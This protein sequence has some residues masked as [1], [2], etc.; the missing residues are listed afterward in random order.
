MRPFDL[1]LAGAE[2]P[3]W[4]KLLVEAQ[5]PMAASYKG[6]ERRMAKT[7]PYL[8]AEKFEGDYPLLLDSG[9]H[10]FNGSKTPPPRDE[11]LAYAQ[12]Y[13]AFVEANIDRVTL[14]TEFDS[15]HLGLDWVMERRTAFYDHLDP[16]KFVAVWHPDWG[17]DVLRD[18]SG[19]YEAVGVTGTESAT[20]SNLTPL[21]HSIGRAG[22]HLHGMAITKPD[23]LRVLPF[24]SA[25]ST[26]WL[27][28]MQYGDTIVW[29]GQTL[30]RYPRDYKDR[31][32][33]QHK[34]LFEREGFDA[35]AIQKGEATEVARFTIWSWMRFADALAGQR[36]PRPERPVAGEGAVAA[37]A[38]GQPEQ[39]NAQSDDDGPATGADGR[40]NRPA[41]RDARKAE[42]RESYTVLPVIG[43]E[44]LTSEE[45]TEDG[46]TIKHERKLMTIS[47]R[48]GRRCNNCYVADVCV[49]FRPDAACAYDI[50]VEAKTAEQRG[51]IRKG[52]IEMQVQR[53]AFLKLAEDRMGGYP[54]PNL[55]A[56]MDRL[57]KLMA[58]DHEIEDDRDSF[59]MTIKSKGH[60]S[61]IDRI[62]GK[63]A[64]PRHGQPLEE[65]SPKVIDVDPLRVLDQKVPLH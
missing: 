51:R 14:V 13:E 50:P 47:E 31:A 30:H 39:E 28:P 63:E 3:G 62:F 58:I 43:Q 29:D 53:V 38:D 26:S 55:T 59:E 12:R 37:T 9:A 57:F 15:T 40:Q 52:V 36:L 18:T 65:V 44:V 2:I 1:Y 19:R 11:L 5:S 54:D 49:D 61:T 41:P 20:G 4:R 34:A 6:I 64:P 48:S 33:R 23:I 35:E 32:R 17:L 60:M 56:E 16:N 42:E 7:K 45:T 10:S 24:R 8:L 25:S 27:S 46:Q 21:L 22:V